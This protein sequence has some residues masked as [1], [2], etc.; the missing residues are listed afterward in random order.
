MG[1]VYLIVKIALQFNHLEAWANGVVSYD[2]D[3][4]GR[5]TAMQKRCLTLGSNP[6]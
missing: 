3:F 6:N 5:K 2:A 4:A 1:M